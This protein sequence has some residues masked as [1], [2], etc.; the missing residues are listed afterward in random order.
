M[1]KRNG[2]LKRAIFESN[3]T[4]RAI[5]RQTGIPESQLSLAIHG[6]FILDSVQK[7]RIAEVLQR[8]QTDIFQE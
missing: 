7:A 6:K 2:I 3:M 8:S 1:I 4:Q 5:A